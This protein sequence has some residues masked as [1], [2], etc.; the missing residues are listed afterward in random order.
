MKNE[1][2]EQAFKILNKRAERALKKEEHAAY[3][4]YTSAIDIIEYALREDAVGLA[5]FDY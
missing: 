2:L 3:I 1:C 4:A 5:Q